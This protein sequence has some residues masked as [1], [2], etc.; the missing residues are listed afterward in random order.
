MKEGWIMNERSIGWVLVVAGIVV[1]VI[2]LL[3]LTG[4]LN[5]FGRLPGD[6]RYEG[7][8]TRVYV[9]FASMLLISLLLSFVMYLLRRFF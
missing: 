1:V 6:F 9:P 7:Q 5:W 2:G 3:A 8:R 4:A